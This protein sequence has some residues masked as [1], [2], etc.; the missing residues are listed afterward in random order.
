[1][2]FI[3]I[4]I[5]TLGVSIFTA[6]T[7]FKASYEGYLSGEYYFRYPARTI[8]LNGELAPGSSD[9]ADPEDILYY[10]SAAPV[11]ACDNDHDGLCEVYYDDKEYQNFPVGRLVFNAEDVPYFNGSKVYTELEYHK[12]LMSLTGSDILDDALSDVASMR[13]Y[14]SSLNIL[15][16]LIVIDLLGLAGL[17]HIRHF[18]KDDTAETAYK[19]T[20]YILFFINLGWDSIIAFLLIF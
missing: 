1:M 10:T 5:F 8:T 20:A 19:I 9:S 18:G 15:K 13:G 2:L 6:V 7:E 3:T 4:L 11:R 14:R 16:L 17:F 12:A